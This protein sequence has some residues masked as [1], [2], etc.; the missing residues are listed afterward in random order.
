MSHYE[1]NKYDA[2]NAE[3]LRLQ[4]YATRCKV[5]E[6]TFDFPKC[7]NSKSLP[8]AILAENNRH[9]VHFYKSVRY[10]VLTRLHSFDRL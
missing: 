1:D 5:Y 10:N 2:L 8:K 4:G 6:L 7:T 3:A 9:I